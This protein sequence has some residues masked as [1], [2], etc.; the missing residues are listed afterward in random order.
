MIAGI[1]ILIGRLL[2]FIAFGGFIVQHGWAVIKW[3]NQAGFFAGLF[4]LCIPI[5][6][7]I[8]GLF[9]GHEFGILLA[10]LIV[11]V[12]AYFVGGA[13][14]EIADDDD[15]GELIRAILSDIRPFIRE[16][17]DIFRG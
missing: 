4:S 13:L 16:I 12:I 1:L 9:K 10:I 3:E 15:D 11:S 17:R 7:T 14:R 8:L 6:P 2:T 5:A